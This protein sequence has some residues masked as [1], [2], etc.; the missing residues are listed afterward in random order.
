MARAVSS[1]PKETARR[2]PNQTQWAAQFLAAAE[3]ERQG[4]VVC[5][6]LGNTRTADLMVGHPKTGVQFW[7]DVKGSAPKSSWMVKRKSSFPNLFYILVFVSSERNHDEFFILT[8][9]ETNNLIQQRQGEL[10]QRDGYDKTKWQD[11]FLWRSPLEHKEK[12]GKLPQ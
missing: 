7:V 3:L 1:F 5:F 2:D 11:G 8:Q 4:Y 12:W 6:T 10:F 9:A